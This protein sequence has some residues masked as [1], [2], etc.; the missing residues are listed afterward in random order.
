MKRPRLLIEEWLPAV[1]HGGEVQAV[2]QVRKLTLSAAFER[3]PELFVRGTLRPPV[4]LGAA[5][6]SKPK[7]N[8]SRWEACLQ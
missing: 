5:W 7:T 1:V 2:T 4:V 6:I 8:S 3:H